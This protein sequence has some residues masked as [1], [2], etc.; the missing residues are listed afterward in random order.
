MIAREFVE[1]LLSSCDI[2]D[3]VSSYVVLKRA[4]RNIKGLCPFHS[5]KTPSM[6]V[7]PDSQS[8]YCFGCGAGGDI[9]AFIMRAEN[10]EYPDAVRF[11]ARKVGMT[12]PEDG[13]DKASKQRETVFNINR[14]TALF[15]HKCLKSPV[16]EIGYDYFKERGLSDKTIT[17]YGLGYAPDTWNSLCN[18]LKTKGYS[19]NDLLLANVAAK[20]K[21]GG[22]YD[23]FRNRVI[24]PIID[25]KGKVIGFGGRVLDDSKPKYLNS[26]DTPVFKK[27]KNLFSLNFAKT[28]IK[29]SVILAEG[30]MDVIAISAA[31]FKNVV[32]TLGTSLTEE[33]ARLI[34]KY[35]KEVLIAYDSDGPGQAA[36]MRA[37]NLF[38][39]VGIKTRTLNIEGAKDP[40][41]YIKKFGAKRFELLLQNAGD[42]VERR[43]SSLK[44]EFDLQTSEGKIAFLKRAVNV[45]ATVKNPL[46]RE[47]YTASVA[48]ASGVMAETV[49]AQTNSLIAKN[50]RDEQKRE[51]RSIETGADITHNRI[52]PQKPQNLKEALAEE[53]II[54]FLFKNPDYYEIIESKISESDFVTDFNLKVY[55]AMKTLHSQGCE[56]SISLLVP[57]FTSHEIGAVTGIIAKSDGQAATPEML[58]DYIKILI[59][60]RT[61]AK[62]SAKEL[63]AEEIEKF[64]QSLK[65]K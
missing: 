62:L 45:L 59:N 53:G 46:E 21:N 20:R 7:Y 54:S 61:K 19:E 65:N 30:Y 31:G 35:A 39:E 2:E 15:F 37:V 18:F 5:E 55:K 16:G 1:R 9:I 24:F 34:S 49:K 32:A 6:V 51:W 43:L 41:E 3:I 22:V 56:V 11:L 63:D 14:E 60:H 29:D 27:S 4:G 48:A 26:P 10:L 28:E 52:N 38:S 8:F 23:L 47:V 44:A 36:T 64:R 42:I 25:V 57:M 58:E 12:V 40:D 13:D 17:A 50:K 33:Q